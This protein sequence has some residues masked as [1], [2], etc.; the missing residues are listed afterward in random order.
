MVEMY[1][2][3]FLDD[4][5][6]EEFLGE[7]LYEEILEDGGEDL[8]LSVMHDIVEEHRNAEQALLE[9]ARDVGVEITSHSVRPE[10]ATVH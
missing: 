2:S 7:E 8:A 5:S 3:T 9:A 4:C 10:G 6:P 1:T